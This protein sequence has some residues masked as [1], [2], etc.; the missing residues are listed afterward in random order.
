M[1]VISMT[2]ESTIQ[3]EIISYLSNVAA[4]EPIVYF[5][6]PNESLMLALKMFRVS[7]TLGYKIVSFFKKM[8]LTPGIPDLC[9]CHKGQSYFLEVKNENGRVSERQNLIHKALKKC[10]FDVYIVRSVEDVESILNDILEV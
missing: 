8:G 7:E 9:V 5:A 10:G 4:R 3:M 1:E 2:K 6:V